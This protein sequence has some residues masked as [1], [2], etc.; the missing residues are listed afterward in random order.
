MIRK[1]IGCFLIVSLILS[2]LPQKGYTENLINNDIISIAKNQLGVP[3]QFGGSSPSG[4]DCSGFL[5]YVFKENGII[6]PRTSA[7]QYD[8]GE[9]I[10]KSDLQI[11]DLVFFETYKPGPSHSGIYVGEQK[12]IHASSKNGISIS[13]VDDPYY[14]SSRYLGARR[15]VEEPEQQILASLPIGQYHDV[16]ADHWAYSQIKWLGEQK[17]MNGYDQSLFLPDD[18]VTRSQAAVIIT[19]T[20]GLNVS[21]KKNEF[22]DVPENHWAAGAITAIND[23]GY[24]QGYEGDLFK[25]EGILTREQ[26]AVLFSRVFQLTTNENKSITFSDVAENYWAHTAIQRLTTNGIAS[27]YADQTYRP[28]QEVTRAEFSVFLFRALHININ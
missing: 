14:W 3:Y 9:K 16:S 20:L 5:Y 15:I 8:T 11:G 22:K 12:F 26:V 10:K 23:S 25:P 4:F 7:D 19:N 13:S 17:M 21:N 2:L 24:L 27:G 1:L 28:K 18:V 6:L